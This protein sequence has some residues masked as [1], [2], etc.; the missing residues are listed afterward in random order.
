MAASF[1]PAFLQNHWQMEPSQLLGHLSD[2]SQIRQKHERQ[3][4]VY[5]FFGKADSLDFARSNQI[6]HVEGCLEVDVF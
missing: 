6:A 4:G 1:F 3:R 5:C 2:C